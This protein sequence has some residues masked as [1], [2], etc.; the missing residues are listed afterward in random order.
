MNMSNNTIAYELVDS[1]DLDSKQWAIKISEGEFTDTVFK[2][3]TITPIEEDGDEFRISFDYEVYEPED[4]FEDE[5]LERFHDVISGILNDILMQQLN[6]DVAN[7]AN[8]NID[9]EESDSQ[10]TVYEES[11]SV[12]KG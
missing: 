4:P 9:S 12:S 3:G 1:G 7:G 11:V 6:E 5:K 10:S 8:R 2:F